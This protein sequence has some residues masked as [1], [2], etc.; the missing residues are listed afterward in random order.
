MKENKLAFMNIMKFIAAL[1]IATVY[2]YTEHFASYTGAPNYFAAHS[3]LLGYLSINGH[4]FVELFF[5]F[6]GILFYLAY[7][8]K[9]SAGDL[10]FGAFIKRRVQRIYPVMI[11]TIFVVF[12]E[13]LILYAAK[14]VTWSFSATIA[15][16][17]LVM[18]CILGGQGVL[19]RTPTLNGPVWYVGVL[20]ECYIIAFA[21]QKLAAKE[22][23]YFL[24]ALPIVAGAYINLSGIVDKPFFNTTVSRGLISFFIGV[25]LSIYFKEVYDKAGTTHK[26]MVKIAA[27]V[28][29]LFAVWIARAELWPLMFTDVN[30]FLAT[31]VYPAVAVLCYDFTLFN[32]LCDTKPIRYL[33]S[34]S[35]GIYLWNFPVLCFV[36]MLIIFGV[37][38]NITDWRMVI[39]VFVLHILAGVLSYE[40]LE[41]KINALLR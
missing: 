13:Q 32:R 5:L 33:G 26:V 11:I 7:A 18:D 21:I 38:P 14:G 22:K 10:K 35:F 28:I 3:S 41:K 25:L 4:I 27:A 15:F 24:Y 30:C 29:I 2:H 17:D 31:L 40:F 19:G 39:I 23:L 20:M 8:E 9:I 1:V 16:R 37:I 36:F 34:I 12:F 6:S